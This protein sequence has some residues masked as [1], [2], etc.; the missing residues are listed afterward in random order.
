MREE[1]VP[2]ARAA[3]K[4][5]SLGL[6]LTALL[7]SGTAS[8]AA[9]RLA[10]PVTLD[11]K[12]TTAILFLLL[13]A[14][15]ILG[16]GLIR[17]ALGLAVAVAM[18]F[19]WLVLSS[20]RTDSPYLFLIPAVCAVAVISLARRPS[21]LPLSRLI[22]ASAILAAAAL[23]LWPLPGRPADG[24]RLLLIGI[25]GADWRVIDPLVEAGRMPNLKRLLDGGHK[26]DLRSL[27]SMYSP[28]VWTTMCTGCEPKI[29]GIH[30]FASKACNM[31]VG[32]IWNQM[33][34]EG[35]SVGLCD[36]YFTWPPEPFDKKAG[37]VVPS[38]LAPD[39]ETYPPK[40]SFYRKLTE[41]EGGR[42]KRGARAQASTYIAAGI[43][44]WRHGIRL[45][46][47]RGGAQE[48]V[49]RKSGRL[50]PKDMTWRARRL[51]TA[52]QA[53]LFSEMIR[54]RGPELGAVLFTEVDQ[55]SHKFWKYMEPEG[56]PEVTKPQVERYGRAIE[57]VYVETDKAI[58]KILGGAPEDVDVII[59]S[60][61]GFRAV[62]QR[63]ANEFRRVRILKLADEI[64]LGGNLLGV[65]I[66][67]DIYIWPTSCPAADREKLLDYTEDM[68][69]TGYFIGQDL[70][71]FII[72]REE[73]QLHLRLPPQ[74]DLS[75]DVR[76]SLGGRDYP[77]GRFVNDPRQRPSGD[78]R[79]D[80]VY[81][82][83][84]PSAARASA[85]DSLHV[86]DV[87]PTIAA[88]L[89]LPFCPRWPGRPALEGFSLSDVR[90][91]EYLPPG[92][93]DATP[94]SVDEALLEKLK[95]LGYM[96]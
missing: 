43:Q 92:D 86:L 58:G 28:Q 4:G 9:V 38:G 23:I 12:S 42:E 14:L 46:T 7:L 85:A 11:E 30:S 95:S 47:L 64:G 40:Y 55:V 74:A 6:L 91:A 88:L 45:S 56:F 60:D 21:A 96:E 1:R 25:D 32:T 50:T 27:D 51:S 37:F 52:L 44:A 8:I 81:L 57:E 80:G 87:T 65:N 29:H 70:P 36:W 54:V 53:D 82:L 13:P 72:E 24:T 63:E 31:R 76:V 10:T 77:L 66:G 68:L 79:P 26:A 83:A 22:P 73:G 15:F 90:L 33:R 2:N 17:R 61:H 75:L 20:D 59:V 89:D 3:D 84:G 78:H 67:K 16:L 39:C 48:L 49:A 93:P 94:E 41:L 34:L 71:L 18:P 69:M 19:V 35:R 62:T 5:G